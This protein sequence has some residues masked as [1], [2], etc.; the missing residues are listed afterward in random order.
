MGLVLNLAMWDD[1]M[2][3]QYELALSHLHDNSIDI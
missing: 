1:H 2:P 3:S